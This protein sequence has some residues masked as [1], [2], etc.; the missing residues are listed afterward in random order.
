MMK[1]VKK[2]LKYL[3]FLILFFF[4]LLTITFFW[5]S[6]AN[7]DK[8][9][10]SKVIEKPFPNQNSSD[11]VFSIVSYNIG[12][13]S[14]MTN[15]RA[16]DRTKDLY[17]KNLKHVLSEFKDLDADVICLQEIDFDSE[18][19][20][21][22]NQQEAIQKLGY[23]YAFQAVNWDKKHLPFPGSNFDLKMHYGAIYSGQSIISKFPLGDIERQVLTRPADVSFL[24][25]AFYLD[26]LAQFATMSI[27]GV[28]IQVI[29][30]HLEA[31]D[32]DTRTEQILWLYNWLEDRVEKMPILLVGDF[33]SDIDKEGS[34]I[35]KLMELPGI[36]YAR[37]GNVE[38]S[39]TFPSDKPYKRLDYIFYTKEFIALQ[40]A[41]ILH[42]FG[43]SSDHLPV[44]MEFRVN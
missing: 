31:F 26:R 16:V 33:N 35:Q 12:Y 7:Y 23:P 34:A 18:R 40:G 6:S 22:V 30:V 2:G 43:E 3:F 36:D 10:Y 21:Y 41:K 29:N 27:N 17:D 5:A 24:R 14:G 44:M 1:I 20:Y 8:S 19:S 38:E 9:E 32:R 28:N 15:N 37:T 4:L 25:D 39:K 11:S 42:E 13:L